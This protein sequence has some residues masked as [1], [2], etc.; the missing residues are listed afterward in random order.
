MSLRTRL[1]GRGAQVALRKRQVPGVVRKGNPTMQQLHINR[2]LTTMSVAYMQDQ[3]EYMADAIFPVLPVDKPSDYYYTYS[4]ADLL[5]DEAQRRAPATESAGGGF[6]I[7]TGT[8]SVEV[9]AFHKDVAD[10]D[11]AAADNELE[12]DRVANEYVYDKLLLRRER[13]LVQ[14][15][16]KAGVWGRD[17]VGTTTGPA[18]GP[19]QFDNPNS[20]PLMFIAAEKL[21]QRRITGRTPNTLVIGAEVLPSLITH[22]AI[23]QHYRPTSS[24]MIDQQK[25]QAYLGVERMIVLGGVFNAAPEDLVETTDMQFIGGRH[26]WLG[27]VAPRP[28][29]MTPSAGYIFAWRGY[30]GTTNG[31]ATSKFRME[32]LKADRVEGEL[33]YDMR[34]VCVDMGTFVSDIIA[35]PLA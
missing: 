21:R 23:R 13:K 31:V 19:L 4:K 32:H 34:R 18:T 5:R 16:F 9:D 14:G 35:N 22:P 28:N 11:R 33:A 30:I 26:L 1:A 10:Q 24:E 15:F 25:V 20:D 27:Y 29:R 6:R 2:P 12:L 7:G 17:L 8:Y 3:T